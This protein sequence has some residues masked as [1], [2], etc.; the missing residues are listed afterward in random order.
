VL[1]LEVQALLEVLIEEVLLALQDR[2]YLLV[3]PL[4]GQFSKGS[5]LL[6]HVHRCCGGGPPIINRGHIVNLYLLRVL[7]ASLDKQLGWRGCCIA[8]L[9]LFLVLW[10]FNNKVVV[11]GRIEAIEELNHLVQLVVVTPLLLPGQSKDRGLN[12]GHW[13]GLCHFGIH[14]KNEPFLVLVRRR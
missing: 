8:E 14:H 3:R 9:F 10:V 2:F 6:G 1:A 12:L 5:I 11:T 4:W 7:E 13:G